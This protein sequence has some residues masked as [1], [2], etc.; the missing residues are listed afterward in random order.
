VTERGDDVVVGDPV[1][2]PGARDGTG[3]AAAPLPA[4]G[5]GTPF[6]ALPPAWPCPDCGT[7]LGKFRL[8][9]G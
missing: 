5:A 7:D 2:A 3:A 1:S 6:T 9:A 8:Y 4:A